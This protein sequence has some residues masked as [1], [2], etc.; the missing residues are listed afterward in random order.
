MQ[1]DTA[2]PLVA[3]TTIRHNFSGTEVRLG[4]LPG[5]VDG[6]QTSDAEDILAVIDGLNGIVELDV[7]QSDTNRDGTPAPADILRVVDLLNGA[8]VYDAYLDVSL[9]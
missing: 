7:W 2:I 4:Y 9:P 1:L 6:S 5:D 3:W 8:G